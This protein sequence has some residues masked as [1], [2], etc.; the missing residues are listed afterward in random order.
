M[1]NCALLCLCRGQRK[2]PIFCACMASVIVGI[3]GKKPLF[4]CRI[5]TGSVIGD[6]QYD[7]VAL[8]RTGSDVYPAVCHAVQPDC[9]DTVANQ[10]DDDLF[11]L[12]PV[13]KHFTCRGA[14]L[15]AKR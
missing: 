8:A 12:N 13:D 6:T 14:R 2:R 5:D 7:R 4:I 9:L 10:V 15:V 1:A 3:P 11:N